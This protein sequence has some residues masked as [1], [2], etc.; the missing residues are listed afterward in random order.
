MLR[1]VWP[2][3]LT[4]SLP[5]GVTIGNLLGSGTAAVTRQGAVFILLSGLVASAA[6][7]TLSAWIVPAAN[8]AL[9][10][11]VARSLGAPWE[12]PRTPTEL[13]LGELKQGLRS[14]AF[15]RQPR[16]AQRRVALS[17]YGRW[18]FSCAPLVFSLLVLSAHT[19]RQ[20]ARLTL[21]IGASF[22]FAAYVTLT[23]LAG[24]IGVEGGLPVSIAAWI[25]NLALIMMA[26]AWWRLR[27]RPGIF[28]SQSLRE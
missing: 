12:P 26:A 20:R 8:Q 23:S 28:P 16:N 22:V 11:E 13:T 19:G 27:S 21:T 10:I 3:A 2:Q 6:S 9:R 24:R 14:P 1:A 4:V 17:Y 18:A 5:I 25:P 7:F 15:W